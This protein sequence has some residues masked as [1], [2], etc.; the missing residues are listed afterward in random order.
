[1]NSLFGYL[2][3]SALGCCKLGGKKHSKPYKRSSVHLATQPAQMGLAP[4][5]ARI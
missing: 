3:K 5:T 2:S 4:Q 1:M